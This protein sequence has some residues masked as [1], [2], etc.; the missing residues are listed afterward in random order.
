MD[1]RT[2]TDSR[3]GLLVSGRRRL[4][5]AGPGTFRI[6]VFTERTRPL[7]VGLPVIL[8]HPCTPLAMAAQIAEKAGGFLVYS[9]G[10][11]RFVRK[12]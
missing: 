5:G 6:P 2:Q 1:K 7:G 11:V 10:K 4:A 9:G 12:A 8:F 3:D